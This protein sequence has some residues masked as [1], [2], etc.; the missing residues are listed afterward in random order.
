MSDSLGLR[1]GG[2]CSVVRQPRNKA[3]TTE[4]TMWSRAGGEAVTAGKGDCR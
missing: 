3:I 1:S 2:Q 4:T